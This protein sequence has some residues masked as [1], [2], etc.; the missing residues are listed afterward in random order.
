M[1]FRSGFSDWRLASIDELRGIYD[2]NVEAPGRL[3]LGKGRA[4]T[5]HV[6]GNLFLTGFQWSSNPAINDPFQPVAHFRFF[7]YFSGSSGNGFDDLAE[8]DFETALCVR[9]PGK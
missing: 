6:K 7:D 3:G 8:G 5:W 4:F 2:K 1:L 9:S